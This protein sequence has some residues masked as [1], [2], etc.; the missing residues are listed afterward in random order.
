VPYLEGTHRA[1]AHT[2]CCPQLTAIV[3]GAPLASMLLLAVRLMGTAITLPLTHWEGWTGGGW[4]RCQRPRNTF[5]Q[6]RR[7][8]AH[9]WAPSA[10]PG[11]ALPNPSRKSTACAKLNPGACKDKGGGW[12]APR[13][14]H[15][16]PALEH[17]TFC[18]RVMAMLSYFGRAETR[19]EAASTA[20][21]TKGARTY[22]N[23][24]ECNQSERGMVQ[25]GK[26][27]GVHNTPRHH[28]SEITA[29]YLTL[30]PDAS[31]SSR[32]LRGPH[33]MRSAV[34]AVVIV[35]AGVPWRLPPHV[36]ADSEFRYGQTTPATTCEECVLSGSTVA[37]CTSTRSPTSGQC[38]VANVGDEASVCQG[39]VFP[40][41]FEAQAVQSGVAY[42][43]SDVSLPR[44]Q[45]YCSYHQTMVG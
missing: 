18:L 31:P 45:D 9:S 3:K 40:A 21:A 13:T 28:V 26:V 32:A 43:C 11:A 35:I 36:G 7:K 25:R 44:Y 39:A 14:A 12:G 38:M 10:V 16:K 42:M 20:A 33:S 15:P 19:A 6:R 41:A 4:A 22:H 23:K 2:K 29:S 27:G 37:W 30:P 24:V 5:F 17:S 8:E 34:A 1:E